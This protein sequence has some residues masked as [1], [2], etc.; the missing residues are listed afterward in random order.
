MPL[1]GLR[2][3]L[4]RHQIDRAHLVNPFLQ[5]RHLP[6]HCL[7]VRRHPAGSHLLRRQHFHLRPPFVRVGN[8]DAFTPNVI[9]LHLI[10]LLNPF[11][12]ILHRHIFLG[13]ADVDRPAGFLQ[14]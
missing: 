11:P 6:R 8:G 12:E 10:F 2:V 4:D 1:F 13:E 7:P 14:F 9:Q 5:R 3:F